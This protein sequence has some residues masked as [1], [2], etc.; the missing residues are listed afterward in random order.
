MEIYKFVCCLKCN[1]NNRKFTN[2]KYKNRLRGRPRNRWIDEYLTCWGKMT[3]GIANKIAKDG[4]VLVPLNADR[5]RRK[6]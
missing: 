4:K 6:G 3:T 1:K 5:K 2:K